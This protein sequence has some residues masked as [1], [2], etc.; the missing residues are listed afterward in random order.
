GYLTKSNT[1]YLLRAMGE[2][3]SIDDIRNIIIGVAPDNRTPVRLYEVADV[4][5][6]YKE[7][8]SL[9]RIN[10]RE[11]VFLIMMK[12][13][14]A[15][16]LNVSRKL[17]KE[18]EAVKKIYP[19][20]EFYTFWDQGKPVERVIGSTSRDIIIG[21]VFVILILLIFLGNLRPTL[22]IAIAVPLSIIT[23]FIVLYLTGFTLNLMTL[24]GLAL[25]VGRLVDD[26]VVVIENI[27][28]HLENGES[29]VH[30]ARNGASEVSMA[31]S[32]STFTTIIVFLPLTFSQGMAQQLTRGFSLT[33]AFTLL[34][35]LFVAF[36]I[37]PMLSSVFFR[38]PKKEPARW[39]NSIKDW[40]GR[41]LEG[42]LRRPGLTL[43]VVVILLIVSIGAGA[44][45]V[46]RE[47]MPKQDSTMMVLNLE[48]PIGTTLDETASMCTSIE[49]LLMSYP[50]ATY[51][52]EVV[53]VDESQMGDPGGASISGPN[54]AQIFVMLKDPE[55]R[56]RSQQE[57]EDLVRLR[58]PELKNG[59]ITIM[60][61]S[62]FSMASGKPIKINI[63]GNNFATLADISNNIIKVVRT[64]PG[65]HDVESS[66]SK[67]RPEYHFVI[68]RQKT[69]LFGLTPYQ[70]QKTIEAANLGTV[71][72]Q[73]RTGDEEIDIRV[74]LDNKFRN[75]LEYLNQLPLKTPSGASISLSQVA[76]LVAAEGPVII[77]RD[78][79]FRTGIVDANYT[80]RPLGAIVKDIQERIAP[81]EKA[82]PSGYSLSFGGE[83]KDMQETFMQLL[84]ALLL[85]ILLAY[86]VM[87]AQFESLIHPLVIGFTIPLAVIGVVWIL[88]LFGKTLSL[89]SFL[90]IIILAGIVLSNGIVLIDYVNQ[91]R[92]K[93]MGIHDALIEGG[94]TRLRPIIVTSI[95]T[96]VGMVPLALDRSES[97]AMASPMAL[98]VIGGLTSSTFLTLF[99]IPV[100]Y[101]YFDRL[102]AWIKRTLV[103]IID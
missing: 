38:K 15:N 27:Y 58:L 65:L 36:T 82:L 76:T 41:G 85:A 60:S 79:K 84:L 81:I 16:T 48:M 46:G 78:N 90:G 103:R 70:V 47:F 1:D 24:G 8:R 14:G 91:L 54:G 43:W 11:S 20:L 3:K 32:A 73:L 89:T 51:V 26:A 74:I 10:G 52:G 55:D 100:V 95:T 66:F 57:I 68:N 7:K 86:M 77:N 25:G 67:A 18:M 33:I 101:Q 34:A 2:F 21:Y 5:D 97:S 44:V 23:T 49:K 92:S 72:S 56:K 93:G 42:V 94:K 69:L 71:F 30:A 75:D 59:K 40:Y 13:S 64:V 6:A 99:I 63:Y 61:T 37:V 4:R 80:G 53:G 31:I 45:F 96:V 87:A 17:V 98:S 22:I 12:Q 62:G 102:G 39:F 88:L 83:Y 28:R 29:P 50:E 35:S 19:Q 9:I